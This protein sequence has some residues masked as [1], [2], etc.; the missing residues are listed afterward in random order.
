MH[1]REPL[2][3]YVLPHYGPTVLY[4]TAWKK[5]KKRLHFSTLWQWKGYMLQNLCIHNGVKSR[6]NPNVELFYD[7]FS[8]QWTH[9]LLLNNLSLIH[10]IHLTVVIVLTV[11]NLHI[12]LLHG[13]EEPWRSRFYC[14]CKG[15]MSVLSIAKA[16]TPAYMGPPWNLYKGQ[17]MQECS[18]TN[19]NYACSNMMWI[20]WLQFVG[21]AL[22]PASCRGFPLPL[23]IRSRWWKIGMTQWLMCKMLV[24]PVQPPSWSKVTPLA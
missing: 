12:S 3:V 21:I 9:I 24:Y 18:H 2:F 8:F 13:L 17:N 22:L 5:A 23:V 6:A 4:H 11:N 1:E 14:V 7:N 19:S 20:T 16:D 15:D 10:T